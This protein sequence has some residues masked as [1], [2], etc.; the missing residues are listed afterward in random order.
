MKNDSL[1]ICVFD[2]VPFAMQMLPNLHLIRM[3][4]SF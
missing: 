4:H 1:E 2:M 3:F